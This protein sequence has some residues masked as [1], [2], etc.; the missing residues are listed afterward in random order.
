MQV[1]ESATVGTV[2][3]LC[4]VDPALTFD[5][6]AILGHNFGALTALGTPT[7]TVSIEIANDEDFLSGLGVLYSTTLAYGD[8]KRIVATVLDHTGTGVSRTYSGVSHARV[9]IQ[10]SAG[11]MDVAPAFSELLLG[12]RHQLR[13]NFDR[14]FDREPAVGL[15]STSTTKSG[16]ATRYRRYGGCRSFSYVS[17]FP[18][19]ADA[20]VLRDAWI[21][22]EHGTRPVLL[23][24]R[25]TLDPRS[26]R[27]GYLDTRGVNMYTGPAVSEVSGT[28]SELPPFVS[29][30][31]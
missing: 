14:P 24:D 25:P 8:P 9:K 19:H 15:A 28:F 3:F 4:D 23:I 2:Y 16:L 31:V 12:A 27:Y 6:C 10:L 7:C 21:G 22:A 26:A 29:S 20:E 17:T 11:T 5:V 1:A 13:Q 30:E 18:T